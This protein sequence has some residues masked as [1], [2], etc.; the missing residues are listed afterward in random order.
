METRQ[1]DSGKVILFFF[2]FSFL[3]VVGDGLLGLASLVSD[4]IYYPDFCPQYKRS[5][6]LH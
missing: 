3:Y 4:R 2:V 6:E 5:S 1:L